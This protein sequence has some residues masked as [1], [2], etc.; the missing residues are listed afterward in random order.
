MGDVDRGYFEGQG[1]YR[2]ADGTAYKGDFKDNQ[3]EGKGV[4]T[5]PPLTVNG[6]TQTIY[7]GQFAKGKR[8]GRG[9]LRIPSVGFKYEGDFRAG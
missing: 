4:L 2:F 3:F 6:H 7:E 9:I 8:E 5:I 1:E